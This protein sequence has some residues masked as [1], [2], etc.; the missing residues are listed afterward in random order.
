MRMKTLI[1]A[2]GAVMIAT[3]ANA[4]MPFVGLWQ[5]IDD[6]TKNAKSIIRLYE[7]G[8]ELC[9][10]VVALYDSEGRAISET[11]SNP[12]RIAEE[13]K[14]KPKMV[15]LDVIWGM[16]WKDKDA[17]YSG[18]KIMDPKSGDVYSSVIWQ[19]KDD[20]KTGTLRVRGQLRFVPL[21]R[22][23]VWKTA[24][25]GL[26]KDIVNSDASTWTPNIIK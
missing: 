16:S 10:R 12:T 6:K 8:E 23:Q 21:G 5:T 2:A 3:G 20:A 4:A 18:G 22:T 25:Q 24:P 26:P 19:E 13:V 15:G 9:G 1:M 11:L 17:E 7:C 14:G